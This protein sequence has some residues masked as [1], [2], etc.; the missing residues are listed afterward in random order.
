MRTSTGFAAAALTTS[1]A[2]E[3]VRPPTATPEIVTPG[4]NVFRGGVVVVVVV[5]VPE[6]TTCVRSDVDDVVSAALRALTRTRSVWPT[7][8]PVSR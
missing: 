2:S 8:L 1:V 5:A 3:S 4:G 7:S 6:V